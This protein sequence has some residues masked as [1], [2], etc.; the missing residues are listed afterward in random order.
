MKAIRKALA[1][2][3]ALTMLV[4]ML[5]ACGKSPAQS[6]FDL[7]DEVYQVADREFQMTIKVSADG[8]TITGTLTGSSYESIHQAQLSGSVGVSGITLEIP[9]ILVDGSTVYVNADQVSD[10]TTM[11]LGTDLSSVF[12]AAYIEIAAEDQSGSNAASDELKKLV[13]GT[14]NKVKEYILSNKNAVVKNSNDSYTLT[15]DGNGLLE[16][17]KIVIKDLSDNRSAYINALLKLS[18][19]SELL[20]RDSLNE[21]WDSL[22]EAAKETDEEL[23]AEAASE[24]QN[25]SLTMTIGKNRDKTYTVSMVFTVKGDSAMSFSID[26]TVTP[27]DTARPF[28]VP[29]DTITADQLSKLV[30]GMTGFDDDEDWSGNDTWDNGDDDSDTIDSGDDNESPSYMTDTKRVGNADAGYIDVPSEFVVFQEEGGL[31]GAIEGFQYSDASGKTVFTVT[32]FDNADSET[33]ANVLYESMDGD[34]SQDAGAAQTTIGGYDA[35]QIYGYYPDDNTYLVIW[36]FEAPDQDELVHYVA[37]EFDAAQYTN[38]WQLSDT[39]SFSDTPVDLS[40]DDD[41]DFDQDDWDDYWDSSEAGSV[42][43]LNLTAVNDSLSEITIKTY[44]DGTATVPVLN[45]ANWVDSGSISSSLTSVSVTAEDYAWSAIYDSDSA[46][47]YHLADVLTL[48][49][50]IFSSSG[51]ELSTTEVNESADGKVQIGALYGDFG[52]SNIVN[53]F[54]AA[55]CG[56]GEVA[57]ID[58]TVFNGDTSI[59]QPILD[60]Y[61][62]ADPTP[63]Q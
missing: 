7:Y 58:F 30:Q 5:S 10:L 48:Y 19:D 40:D 41:T 35:Y 28:A 59:V 29:T 27:V 3:L 20:N 63:A 2:L 45:N 36:V 21:M 43:D 16:L 55:D 25:Y 1:T 22:E 60:Y 47:D 8:E 34:G 50:D 4:T 6:F 51:F 49:A 42:D 54:I 26:G 33:I 15:L 62:V 44:G 11:L 14:T 24:L 53:Y 17:G 39:F 46:A 9:E 37:I 31:S 61:G 18:P 52:D 13:E 12:N 56:N 23:S 57:T 38:V 32:A